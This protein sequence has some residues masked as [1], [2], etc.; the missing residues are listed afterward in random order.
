V[1]NDMG[2]VQE[3]AAPD[4][5]YLATE[6]N[7]YTHHELRF[8]TDQTEPLRFIGMVFGFRKQTFE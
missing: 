2:E 6:E 8:S 4:A 1:Y 3:C 5:V 7:E